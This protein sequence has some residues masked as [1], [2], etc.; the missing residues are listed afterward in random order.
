MNHDQTTESTTDENSKD[1][2]NGSKGNIT[3]V[4]MRFENLFTLPRWQGKDITHA[5]GLS[6]RIPFNF[7]LPN[8]KFL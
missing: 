6:L 5:V 7:Y 8:S 2:E 3:L 1:F 4:R